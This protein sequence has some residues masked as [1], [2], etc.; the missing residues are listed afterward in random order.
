MKDR[1]DL[2]VPK[3]TRDPEERVRDFLAT[4]S[5]DLAEAESDE[6][7]GV[8]RDVPNPYSGK[9]T[10]VV[11][12][13]ADNEF[14]TNCITE[15]NDPNK[16]DR[17]AVVGTPG[18][19]KSTTAF[20]LIKLLLE[21]RD[22][23]VYVRRSVDQVLHY[24]QLT[25][26][27]DDDAEVQIHLFPESTKQTEIDA[28]YDPETYFIVDPGQTKTNCNPEGDVAARVVIVASPDE[29]HWGGNA[30]SKKDE[31]GNGGM[32]PY[33]PHWSFT[34][35]LAGSS[36]LRTVSFAHG[37]IARLF[38]V[39]GGIP[40]QVFSPLEE[41]ENKADLQ[42]RVTALKEQQVKDLVKGEVN[43]HSGF[44]VNQPYGG[45]VV[46]KPAA[47][48]IDAELELASD[49]ILLQV[50]RRFM[51]SLWNELA[52]YP[53]LIVWQLIEEYLLEAL[54]GSNLYTGRVC[55]GKLHPAYNQHRQIHL[56]GCN[57][58]VL[59]ADC[60]KAV[61]EGADHVL[62]FL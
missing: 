61:R 60:T 14:W 27:N 23:V 55:I 52:V 33:F 26:S 4:I 20:Y 8:M 34:E 17:V 15:L 51:N 57:K 31:I 35:L 28:L 25:P 58:K 19:G 22:T 1:K 7:F 54:Q 36:E 37:Q 56:G 42:R 29:R 10:N 44:G 40:R 50:R 18:I 21:R 43:F 45:I 32:F 47:G 62:Y 39:F 30:F 2:H 41:R 53:S 12:R 46:F 16:R 59:V 3:K 24:V 5:A 49:Y 38:R 13:I 11:I 9:V 48:Y 6:I